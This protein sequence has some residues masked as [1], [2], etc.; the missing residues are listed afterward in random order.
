[1]SDKEILAKTYF[2]C[3]E[4]DRCA[5]LLQNTTSPLGLFLKLYALYIVS[6]LFINKYIYVNYKLTKKKK[7][8]GRKKKRRG[9]R[10]SI[11]SKRWNESKSS[12]CQN[13]KRT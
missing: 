2:D 9:T 6:I 1:M 10:R 13:S 11:K 5:F 7:T 12:N 8:V 3:H 4:Y